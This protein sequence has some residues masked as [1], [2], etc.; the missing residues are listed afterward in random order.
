MVAIA[1]PKPSKLRN[2]QLNP[3]SRHR[4]EKKNTKKRS[5]SSRKNPNLIPLGKNKILDERNKKDETEVS[6]VP[7]CEATF[8]ISTSPA[9]LQ[10]RYFLDW[11]QSANKVKLSLL[12]LD[13]FKGISFLFLLV[14]SLVSNS[15]ISKKDFFLK[16]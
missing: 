10:L 12:E 15:C 16:T 3:R 11:F 5:R 7:S 2:P 6:G 1:K 14:V 9:S 4:V 13:A 8:L